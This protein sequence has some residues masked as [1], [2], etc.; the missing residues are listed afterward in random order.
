[1]VKNPHANAG[2]A[3]DAGDV[4]SIPGSGISPGEGKGSPLQYHCLENSLDRRAW[5]VHGGCKESDMI[6][7][8]NDSNV[9]FTKHYSACKSCLRSS[10][11]KFDAH[12]THEICLGSR[13]EGMRMAGIPGS[14]T[15]KFSL[16]A[17]DGLSLP[18]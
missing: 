7:Q 5:Q 4:G 2:N 15:P 13:G 9:K 18:R 10:S 17:H 1:M 14:R 8:L 6:E 16:A 3:G 12:I 11:D